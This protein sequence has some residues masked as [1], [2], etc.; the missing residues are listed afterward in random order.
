MNSKVKSKR[1][2]I[3]KLRFPEFEGE[4]V[5]YSIGC[6]TDV[7]AGATPSTSNPSYWDGNIPW[8]NSGELN[9]KKVFD[10]KNRITK[11][12]LKES[13]TKLIPVNS[14]LVGLAGQGKTRGTVAM[15]YI[16][17]CINQSIASILPN[18]CKF[19]P[20]FLFYKLDS[21]Y[22]YL[23]SISK[24]EG[25]RGG[26]NLQLIKS[27]KVQMPKILPEQQKI[28]NC[29]SSI[30]RV[31]DFEN[32]KLINLK[33][34]KKGLLQKLFPTEGEKV[35]ELRF[36]EFEREWVEKRLGEVFLRIKTKNKNNNSNI[37]T[38]SAQHGLVNQL[39]FFK[40]RIASK[41]LTGYYLL[42]KGDF[43]YNKSYSNGYPMGAIKPLKYYNSGVVST[44]YICFR[45]KN[46]TDNHSSF[47]EQY[48]D[49]GV[50]NSEL[51]KIAQEG[52]RN[53]GLLNIGINDF[54]EKVKI[55][56][57]LPEEQQKIANCLSSID[58]VIDLQE[59]KI[60]NLKE[61]KKG[62]MQQ[63]FPNIEELS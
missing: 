13:S 27:V 19:V 22:Q 24:G 41:D 55:Y 18:Q 53:H 32:D 46:D 5:D 57:P 16:E 40:K 48:F 35:P 25:G 28:A 11:L 20:N 1:A 44:L 50:L 21:M 45:I 8:M 2:L 6:L 31:I 54:F 14:V 42:H 15:N 33:E 7:I 43:A 30:D 56:S 58:K 23:R 59:E 61:H 26:L 3:P 39:Q 4:W 37:L 9:K 62:L 34:H 52:G 51:S 49:A 10:V 47:F 12:G 36:P 17:L 38:I 63:L 60:T 29:L